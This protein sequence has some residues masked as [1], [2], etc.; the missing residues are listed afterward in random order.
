MKEVDKVYLTSYRPVM[1]ANYQN[2]D[3]ETGQERRPV[4][5]VVG[6]DKE[7]LRGQV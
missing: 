4:K 6:K 5:Q 2:I 1:S 7:S 3:S